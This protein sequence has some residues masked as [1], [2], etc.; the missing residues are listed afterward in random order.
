MQKGK[1][2]I[3]P[4]PIGN[5]KDISERAKFLLEDV[6][7]I[8]CEDSRKAGLLFE[9]LSLTKKRFLSYHDHNEIE[10]AKGIVKLIL[11]GNNI[12]LISDAGYPCISDPGYRL[13]NESI[14]NKIEIIALPGTSSILPALVCSGFETN[15]FT[16]LG[17]P[18]AKKGRQTFIND[19][20]NRKET[21]VIFESVHKIEKLLDQ[22]NNIDSNRKISIS[23]EISKV[24]EEVIRGNAIDC[25]NYLQN[26]TIKGEFVIVIERIK[27]V[28]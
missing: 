20:L 9:R 21:V 16:F 27:N 7:I 14:N 6:D 15:N 28:H 25:L 17:F 10:S 18:P 12:G 13:V 8:A 3:I 24:H 11:E 1:L 2:Y 26:N 19:V 23:R 22:I 4:T 5:L